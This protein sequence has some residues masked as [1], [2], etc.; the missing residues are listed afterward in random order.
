M[1]KRPGGRS[2]RPAA[3]GI[4]LDTRSVRG[5][6]EPLLSNDLDYLIRMLRFREVSVIDAFLD[7][8]GLSLGSWYPLIFL[9]SEDGIS[10]RELGN[11]LNLKDASI[12]K[13]IDVMEEAGLLLRAA[14]PGDRRKSLVFLTAKGKNMAEDVLRHRSN[15]LETMLHGFSS[16]EA[17]TFRTYLRRTYENLGTFLDDQR[18]NQGDP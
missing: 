18:P 3:Q 6:L 5:P 9:H 2:S 7:S 13:A 10:Q 15:L 14:D 17:E 16:T 4:Q 1:A 12:G 8:L 11:R